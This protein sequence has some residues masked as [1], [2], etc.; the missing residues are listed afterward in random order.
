[1]L[2]DAFLRDILDDPDDDAPRLVYADWLEE[3]GGGERAEFIRAQVQRLRLPTGDGR[4]DALRRRE[5]QLLFKQL[6]EWRGRLG[7]GKA[8]LLLRRGFVEGMS[9][10]ATS[11]QR[12]AGKV[13]AATPLRR[14][15]L[16]GAGP[17]LASLCR[18]PHLARLTHL[19]L[20]GESLTDESARLLATCSHL[21]GLT[22][23]LLARNALTASGAQALALSPHLAN[24]AILDLSANAAGDEGARVLAQSPH[25]RNLKELFLGGNDVHDAGAQALAASPNLAGLR[26][27]MLVLNQIGDKGARAL[28]SSPHLA[29]LEKLYLSQNALTPATAKKLQKA[30]GARLVWLPGRSGR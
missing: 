27:L 23:L 7:S 12:L 16:F 5:G 3:Q 13:T 14:L 26:E 28:T 6:A 15:R 4:E 25:L 11:W 10:S 21:A 1:M 20:G 2:E 24:L 9:L 18:S 8:D 17:R 29:K 19:D 30:W 22:H